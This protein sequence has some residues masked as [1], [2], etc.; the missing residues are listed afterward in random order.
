[1]GRG[2]RGSGRCQGHRILG[3]AHG[4][5]LRTWLCKSVPLSNPPGPGSNPV[6]RAC[7]LPRL[8]TPPPAAC[9]MGSGGQNLPVAF[10][11]SVW[12]AGQ[13]FD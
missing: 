7:Q 13:A 5:W 8:P 6:P 11:T 4:G 1:M 10:G 2:L 3:G 12:K 9:N